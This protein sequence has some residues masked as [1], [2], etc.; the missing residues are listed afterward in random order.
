MYSS[1]NPLL[2]SIDHV[3]R[4]SEKCHRN[5]KTNGEVNYMDKCENILQTANLEIKQAETLIENIIHNDDDEKVF[6]DID[7]KIERLEQ[8]QVQISEALKTFKTLK[9]HELAE[10]GNT[11][12]NNNFDVDHQLSLSN[13]NDELAEQMRR[14]S[15]FSSTQKLK[16]SLYDNQIQSKTKTM[17]KHSNS[18]YHSDSEFTIIPTISKNG[19]KVNKSKSFDIL[20]SDINRFLSSCDYPEKFN[21]DSESFSNSLPSEL[22]PTQQSKLSRSASEENILQQTNNESGNSFNS[23]DLDA[24]NDS[25]EN[26]SLLHP[27]DRKILYIAKEIMTSEK[28][29]VDVLKLINIDFRN[30]I[31]DAR[32]SSKS[33]IMPTE[34]FLKIFSNLPEI[35]ML[36]SELLRDFE[37]RVQ[38]WTQK[39]K[40]SDIIVMKGP[41]LKLYTTYV[42]NY[43]TMTTHFEDCCEKFPKFKKLVKEFEKF[44]QCRNLKLTHYLL[45]P[46][47]RLPQYKLLLEDYLK[48]LDV[49]SSDYDDTTIALG[50]V[51]EAAEHANETI[52]QMVRYLQQ[53]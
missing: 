40:I 15:Q 49:S 52:K 42:S 51:T 39:R 28:V 43:S 46:I 1:G 4:M 26:S 19:R 3:R 44:P 45:K 5:V 27:D 17:M 11:Y 25:L 13:I 7:K 31:Q 36:N 35:M 20:D 47:Q 37:E 32:K 24:L 29:Y 23:G 8:S 18:E 53:N 50:I 33:Q 9:Q 6:E 21:N 48:Y 22:D 38:N 30:F 12:E 41:Y 16:F 34:Q 2:S 10:N 14:H